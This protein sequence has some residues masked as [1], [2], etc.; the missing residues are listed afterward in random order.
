VAG[1]IALL[2][3]ACGGGEDAPADSSEGQ[4]PVEP[5][6]SEG[7]DPQQ[8]AEDSIR[9]AAEMLLTRETFSYAGGVRDPFESLFNMASTGPEFQDLELVGV[10]LDPD[11]SANTVALLRERA[12]G[13]PYKLRVGDAVG[14][15]VVAQIRRTDVVFTIEDFGFER[16][17]TLALPKREEGTP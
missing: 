8:V 15:A 13:R 16:Q 11:H 7:Q 9:R 10:Y 17:E 12:T 5:T 3:A 14:R 4:A 6:V 2:V 1:L